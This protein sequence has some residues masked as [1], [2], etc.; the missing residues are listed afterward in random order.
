MVIKGTAAI[1][2]SIPIERGVRP[3]MPL[4]LEDENRLVLPSFYQLYGQWF[5][6][7]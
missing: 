3:S 5:G 4:E 1:S 7:S 2:Q 6:A